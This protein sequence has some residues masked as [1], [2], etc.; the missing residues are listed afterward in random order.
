[1]A[2]GELSETQMPP[3]IDVGAMVRGQLSPRRRPSARDSLH[4]AKVLQEIGLV[5]L[6]GDPG[7]WAPEREPI[8]SADMHEPPPSIATVTPT[9]CALLGV[10]PPRSCEASALPE[11]LDGARQALQNLPAARCLIYCPDALGRVV[12]ERHPDALARVVALAPLRV[13]LQ[14]VLP[15]VTP[16]CF[17]TMFT[18]ASPAIH[19]TR[20]YEKLPLPDITLFD[21][22][23]GAGRQATIVAVAGSSIDTIFRQ[24]PVTHFSE[25]YDAEVSERAIGLLGPD[26]PEVMVVYHQEYDDVMHRTE[27]EAPEAV[28]ALQRHVASFERLV[29]AVDAAWSSF[30]RAVIFAPDH[31]VHLD[32]ATGHGT[33]GS[34]LPEDLEVVHFYRFARASQTFA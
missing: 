17:S 28:A 30:D 34:D 32:S 23:A 1:M 14:S 10:P 27:P 24:R 4:P 26:G 7:R 3:P 12:V 21:A 5:A 18:G 11:A 16:V 8:A 33:H 19:G 2:A 31:G 25:P 20:R 15:S 6:A 22:L 29:A 13:G 9:V